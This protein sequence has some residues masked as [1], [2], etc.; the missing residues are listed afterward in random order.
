VLAGQLETL[1]LAYCTIE[2]SGAIDIANAVGNTNA[3]LELYLQRSI[4]G[5]ILATAAISSITLDDSLIGAGATAIQLA[6]AALLATRST[7]S[8]AVTCRTAEAS[9]CIFTRT[10][11]VE[12]HQVGCLRF[13][14]VPAGGQTPRPF[15]CQPRLALEG[16]S[17]PAVQTAIRQRIQPSHVSIQFGDPGFGLLHPEAPIELRTGAEDGA[18]MGVFHHLQQARREARLRDVLEQY[19]RFGLEAG[20]FIES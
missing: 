9:D 13:C 5:P 12:Q 7:I 17:D 8:G 6:G 4:T 14:Y 10:L 18:E 3:S 16:I 2:P 19:L 15:R 1:D 11:T 20:L